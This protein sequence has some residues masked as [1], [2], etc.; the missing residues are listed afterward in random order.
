[1]RVVLK[2]TLVILRTWAFTDFVADSCSKIHNVLLL[3]PWWIILR[4]TPA[5]VYSHHMGGAFRDGWVS[6]NDNFF[7]SAGARA[8]PQV[9]HLFEAEGH[10]EHAHSDDAVHHVHDKTPIGRRHFEPPCWQ[11]TSF[12]KKMSKDT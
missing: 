3:L 9:T 6:G 5:T 4:A 12:G 10:G 1:M 8:R 2:Q 7:T 11:E